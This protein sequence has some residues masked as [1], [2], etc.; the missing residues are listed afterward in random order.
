[1]RFCSFFVGTES[2]EDI[3]A[4]RSVCS[5]LKDVGDEAL[6]TVGVEL[7]VDTDETEMVFVLGYKDWC[8]KCP[9]YNHKKVHMLKKTE[10]DGID[11]CGG[12]IPVLRLF[13]KGNINGRSEWLGF[14]FQIMR[15]MT[16]YT[17]DSAGDVDS[18]FPTQVLLL[19][20]LGYNTKRT[21]RLDVMDSGLYFTEDPET[22][23]PN[24]RVVH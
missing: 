14:L 8:K 22:S 12:I 4:I 23:A 1:M 15:Q 7:G 3:A 20:V 18:S 19:D 13:C 6:P 17:L 11:S 24:C 10:L 21:S 2:L 16:V 5:L 9:I